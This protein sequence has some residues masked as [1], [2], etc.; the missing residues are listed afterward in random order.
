VWQRHIE[1]QT[2]ANEAVVAAKDGPKAAGRD[3]DE[4]FGL[5]PVLLSR[6]NAKD[7]HDLLVYPCLLR[8]TFVNA[9]N[10]IFGQIRHGLR[11]FAAVNDLAFTRT[12]GRAHAFPGFVPGVREGCRTG[13]ATAAAPVVTALF[14]RTGASVEPAFSSL[15]ARGTAIGFAFSGTVSLG[16]A[17][18]AVRAGRLASDCQTR[19]ILRFRVRI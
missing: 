11:L 12:I 13:A 6:E 17:A 9:L 16:H 19:M 8:M 18:H 10:D 3:F 14:V 15:Y 1:H 2:S 7:N 5:L 4:L